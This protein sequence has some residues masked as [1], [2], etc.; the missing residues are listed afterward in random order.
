MKPKSL[1][2]FETMLSA[3]RAVAFSRARNASLLVIAAYLALPL[4]ALADPL[5]IYLGASVGQSTVKADLIGFSQHDPAWKV[6]AGIRPFAVLGAEVAYTDFG[7]PSYSLGGGAFNASVRASSVD[8]FGLVYLPIPV[9]FLDVYG[10]G[11]LANLRYRANSSY[12][13]TRPVPPGCTFFGANYTEDRAAYGVGVQL[14]FDP[15][16]VRAEYERI[17]AS[18]GDPSLL[19]VGITWTFK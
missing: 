17:S 4:A 7:H 1:P 6:L 14:K 15:L 8:V 19:S 10:K 13:C 18:N 9:P 5:G 16:A 11:G 2:Q 3:D 12:V